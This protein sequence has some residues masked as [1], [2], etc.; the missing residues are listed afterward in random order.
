MAHDDGINHPVGMVV[1]DD[2]LVREVVADLLGDLC[3]E[4]YE[5]CDG[6]DGLRVLTS[7][8]DITLVVT[9][10][11]MPRLDGIEFASRARKLHPNLKVLFLSGLQRPPA[12][13][14]FLAKPFPARALVSA[15]QDLLAAH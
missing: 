7:H 3:D 4:V 10:I 1:D 13:E 9:D 15:I 2:Q 5:A 12:S 8:P 6:V 14:N 11:A